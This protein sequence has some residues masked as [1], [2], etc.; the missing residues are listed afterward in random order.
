MATLWVV[1]QPQA[2]AV[3]TPAALP[4]PCRWAL[5]GPERAPSGPWQAHP[6]TAPASKAPA[7]RRPGQASGEL[8][9]CDVGPLVSAPPS[10]SFP[11]GPRQCSPWQRGGDRRLRPP[12]RPRR[13]PRPLS[14]W[15]WESRAHAKPPAP[16]CLLSLTSGRNLPPGGAS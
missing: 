3:K 4:V 16:P 13:H 9:G 8:P 6:G 12:T 10:P 11:T 2:S 1:A 5:Q 14:Y 7:W 15:P